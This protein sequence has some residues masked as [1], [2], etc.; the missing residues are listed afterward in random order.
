MWLS[1][2]SSVGI[3][4]VTVDS[5]SLFVP[6]S[7]TTELVSCFAG[8]GGFGAASCKDS[9][10]ES[11]ETEAG[12]IDTAT[13]TSLISCGD[14]LSL[15][16]DCGSLFGVTGASTIFPYTVP[17]SAAALGAGL[18]WFNFGVDADAIGGDGRELGLAVGF[19]DACAAATS[20]KALG[21]TDVPVLAGGRLRRLPD[22]GARMGVLLTIVFLFL[23]WEGVSG[24][25]ASDG[26]GVGAFVGLPSGFDNFGSFRTARFA[27]SAIAWKALLLG[28]AREQDE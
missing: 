5:A 24:E 8:G 27:D 18:A 11:G 23:D 26:A 28:I 4:F 12:E 3:V 17:K 14:P 16:G 6:E 1:F 7:S 9:E 21:L 10:A 25:A 2:N 13:P 19:G 15:V 22:G 20:S